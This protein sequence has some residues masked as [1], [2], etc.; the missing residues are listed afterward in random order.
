MSSKTDWEDVRK[1]IQE[2]VGAELKCHRPCKTCG[3]GDG[4]HVSGC[5]EGQPVATRAP[6]T[7]P[8]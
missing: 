4:V 5:P 6:E 3:L 7:A 2:E 8:G 1:R